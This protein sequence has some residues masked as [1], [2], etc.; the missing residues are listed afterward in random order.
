[1]RPTMT[2]HQRVGE[3]TDGVAHQPCDF[4]PPTTI[5]GVVVQAHLSP[6]PTVL[7]HLPM[8]P[9]GGTSQLSKSTPK[10]QCKGWPEVVVWR[11]DVSLPLQ[12][13]GVNCHRTS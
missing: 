4:H 8:W 11:G 2:N 1:M 9:P 13:K 3:I 7:S 12:E 5:P 10:K 6:I